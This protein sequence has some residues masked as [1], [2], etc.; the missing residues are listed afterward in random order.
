MSPL[1]NHD[2]TQMSPLKNNEEEIQPKKNNINS[3]QCDYCDKTYKYRQGKSRH[4]KSCKK[5][6][7][8]DKFTKDGAII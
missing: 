4:Q 7:N 5:R 8:N 3:F 1:S 2:V 6:E